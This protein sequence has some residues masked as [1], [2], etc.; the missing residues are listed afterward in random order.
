M[1]QKIPATVVTGF[2]GAGKT[3]LIR[4]LLDAANGKRIALIINEFG[5][6]GVDG[7]ILKGCGVEGC[8]DEDVVELSNGCICCTVAEDFLPAMQKLVERDDAPDH[9]VIETSG[10]ALPQPL[11]RAFNWPDIRTRVTVDGVVAVVDGPALEAGRFAANETAVDAQRAADE[12]IDHET[13]L[14]ELFE[15]QLACADMVVVNKADLLGGTAADALV[16]RL[17]DE[18]RAGVSVLQSEMGM[19]DAAVLLGLGVGAEDDM[20]GRHE[21]HHHHHHHDDDDEHDHD[22]EHA[23]G[24]DE[25]ESFVVSRAEIADPTAFAEHVA[26]VIRTHDIL[27]LKGFAAVTGKPMRLAMQAVGPRID[28]Y[29]DRPFGSGEPRE[30]RLVVIGQA[31]LD[32]AA[33]EKAL[34]A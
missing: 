15:D 20:D 23:H 28:S 30:T 17:R 34:V 26:E 31:G 25:F 13:P 5:D 27:R 1:A 8:R 32:R 11:V 16:T 4:H 12:T 24:H 3:T 21:L 6:L 2:L 33:I 10:L 19:V 18:V 9:I 22:D 29:F 14:S 7:E